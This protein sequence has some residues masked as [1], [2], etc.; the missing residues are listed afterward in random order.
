MLRPWRST[1]LRKVAEMIY[2]RLYGEFIILRTYYG[3]SKEGKEEGD[4][5]LQRWIEMEEENDDGF[6]EEALWCRILNDPA[7][8]DVGDEWE[9]V[10]DILPELAGRTYEN[11][12]QR[13]ISQSSMARALG[14]DNPVNAIQ[15][16]AFR[17]S[18]ELPI[19]VA[20]KMAFETDN[21]LVLFLDGHGNL[22]RSSR[23]AVED[24]TEF[25]ELHRDAR[26]D[27]YEWWTEAE[28]GPEYKPTG[29]MG[30]AL[31]PPDAFDDL[32]N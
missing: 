24:M 10:L 27:H 1:E 16:V 5:T 6:E 14:D 18:S 12:L 15:W 8:F 4:A 26:I 19:L 9:R 22:V 13:G 29:T 31:Y 25:K 11:A 17:D 28:V 30:R 3:E 7:V 23:L 2:V 32:E 21:F 20:D